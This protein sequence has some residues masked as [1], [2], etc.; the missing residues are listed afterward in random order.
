MTGR[1]RTNQLL[2]IVI[3][4]SFLLFLSCSGGDK[5]GKADTQQNQ[6]AQA[7]KASVVT[8]AAAD[9][10]GTIHQSSEWIGQKPVVINFWGTWCGPCR[11]E[12][13]ELVR[14]YNE[15][16]AQGIEIISIAVNDTPDRV[17]DYAAQAGMNWVHLMAEKQ[18]LIDYKA[19]TGIPTTIF[20]DKNGKEVHRFIGF[21]GYDEFKQAFEYLAAQPVS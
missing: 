8:F 12:I 6:T 4:F 1:L 7:Q 9:L 3:L 16:Q 17:R 5:S 15:Y 20:L 2:H 21:Q 14:V 13:P 19:T 11:N 18:I 10:D